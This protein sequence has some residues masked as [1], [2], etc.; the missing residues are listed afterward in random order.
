MGETVSVPDEFV[1]LF[2]QT[3]QHVARYFA[4]K[5]FAPELGTVEISGQRYMLVRAASM[6]V[7]FY[8]M[9]RS[10]YGEEGEAAS[11]AH[12]LLFDV[13]HAMALADAHAFAERTGLR[14]QMT[15]LAAGPLIFANAGWAFVELSSE[16]G[17]SLDDDYLM[18]Y[19][20]PY[21]FES[22]SWLKAGRSSDE[23]VCVMNA[24]YSS[25]WCEYGL[26]RPLVAVE[27]MCRA[28]GD[29]ACRFVMS[30]PDRLEG[31]VE[32]YAR[33]HPE[34]A[35]R[36][37][38][39]ATPGFFSKRV[40]R[41]L[42]LANAAREQL[43]RQRA[44]ELSAV[45]E[46]LRQDGRLR[47]STEAALNVSKEFSQRLIQA[48]PGGVVHVSADGTIQHANAE[49]SRVLGVSFDPSTRRY[50]ND[51]EAVTIF[52]DGSP[53]PASEYPVTKALVS[54][55][56]QPGVPLGVRKP[57]GAVSWAVFRAVPVRDPE[58]QE[59]TGAIVSF[60]YITERKRFEE[61]VRQTQKLES[62]GVLAGGVAH[63][64]NNLLV[65]ILGNTS[66]ARNTPGVDERI[67]PLLDEVERGARRAA[68]LTMQM[69][70]YAGQGK[71]RLQALDL[72]SAVRE[73][74][75]LVKAL[76]PKG[77]ELRYHFLEGVPPLEAAATQVRQVIMNLLTNAA[78][79]IGD[80]PGRVVISVDQTRVTES[81]L[82]AYTGQSPLSGTYQYLDVADDGCGMD[83]ATRARVFDPFFTTKFQG[84]GLGMATVLGIVRAHAGAIRIDSREGF[85]TRIRVLFPADTVPP[86]AAPRAARHGTIL[87][88]DDAPGV[89]KLVR[90]AL[91]HR[92]FQ[93]LSAA[94]GQEGI[95]LFEQHREVIRLILMDMTM[96]RMSGVE[97]LREIRARGSNVPIL[98]STGYDVGAMGNQAQ[99][100]SG[101]LEKPYDVQDLWSAVERALAGT[102]RAK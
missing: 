18:I 92:G 11:V 93:L 71:F 82:E 5:N 84:R 16:S 52:E 100:F 22:D 35:D 85:G 73:M 29:D 99:E 45:H 51:F 14:D 21:S 95:A 32:A 50:V 59:V 27:I 94:D 26:G 55:Q 77:V 56:P 44:D 33:R 90:R 57:D 2:S 101:V 62:L 31:H 49:A 78:E 12:S 6:S 61:K 25:G 24:G 69:L 80:R 28:R 102:S 87:V 41:Q 75:K 1:E 36:I 72:P 13:A 98:L 88:V 37:G 34:V 53:A 30:P 23:P 9:V 58:S 67:L 89:Q 54:G 64:F 83:E 40:D 7:E 17:A 86:R 76:L 65:T 47:R 70:D 10:I 68:E 3:R 46:Q 97:A 19:D 91:G 96:P 60:L 8:D 43:A 48:L 15:R 63:D 39:V 74:A 38:K 4:D 20:H 81:D 79:S 66:L 42:L